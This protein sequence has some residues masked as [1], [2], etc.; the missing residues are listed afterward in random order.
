MLFVTLGTSI[1][2]SII[3]NRLLGSSNNYKGKDYSQ[4]IIKNIGVFLFFTG[5][6]AAGVVWFLKNNW[7]MLLLSYWEFVVVYIVLFLLLGLL[8]VRLVRGN[9]DSKHMYVVIVKWFIR[10]TGAVLVYQS[11]SSPLGSILLITLL[12]LSYII[13]SFH[14]WVITRLFTK[15]IVKK[16]Q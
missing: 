5:S 2:I 13:Y 3:I 9:E 1:L 10:I 6:Y 16:Q 14:K 11:S 4:A 15:K 8:L 12:S 7:Q